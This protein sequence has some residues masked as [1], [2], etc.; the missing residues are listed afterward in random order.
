[1]HI[2]AGFPLGKFIRANRERS[3]L[4]GWRQTHDDI[5][6][7]SHSLFPCLREKIR[8]VS[9]TGLNSVLNVTLSV[10]TPGKLKNCLTVAGIEPAIFVLLVLVY[11]SE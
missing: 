8:Q 3:N 9:I 10:S 2:K 4:I 7:Q 5:T 11:Y 6:S 1:M